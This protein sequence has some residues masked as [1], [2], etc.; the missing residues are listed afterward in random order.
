MDVPLVNVKSTVKIWSIFVAFLENM[1]FMYLDIF[2]HDIFLIFDRIRKK[3]EFLKDFGV[4]PSLD[5]AR[6]PQM[7]LFVFRTF[8]LVAPLINQLMGKLKLNHVRK[9]Q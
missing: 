4:C 7:A 5:V 1:N 6:L 9:T 2:F 8:L 3:P